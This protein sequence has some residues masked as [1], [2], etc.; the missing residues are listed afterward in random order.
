[1]NWWISNNR[2]ESPILFYFFA[3]WLEPFPISGKEYWHFV[4]NWHCWCTAIC[5]ANFYCKIPFVFLFQLTS[6]NG[7]IVRCHLELVVGFN[8]VAFLVPHVGENGKI[9]DRSQKCQQ[10]LD[11]YKGSMLLHEF[12]W[13]SYSMSWNPQSPPWKP[14][15]KG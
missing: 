5:N 8:P 4:K 13:S 15:S 10:K 11:Y 1:M 12:F 14:N 7:A 2:R 9:N 6:I 3:N